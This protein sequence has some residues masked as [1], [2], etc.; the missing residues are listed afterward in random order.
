[1]VVNLNDHLGLT[2]TA[3]PA[4]IVF[5]DSVEWYER[6]SGAGPQADQIR[7]S[8]DGFTSVIWSGTNTSTN[9]VPRKVVSG[10]PNFT[11][12]L[13]I[14]FYGYFPTDQGGT[15][16]IDSLRIYAHTFSTLPVELLSFTGKA[17]NQGVELRW[18]TGS[19][20]DN[21]RFEILRSVDAETWREIGQVSGSGTTSVLS[22]Y[23]FVD[24]DPFFGT[25]YYRLRQVDTNGE[26]AYSPVVSVN[27]EEAEWFRL[28]EDRL[29]SE[30]PTMIFD[31]LG[32]LI[33]GP[34]REHRISQTGVLFLQQENRAKSARLFFS[35]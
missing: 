23:L 7:T 5:I 28:S 26:Y 29:I 20:Q 6:R 2:L 9:Y 13:D 1:M 15:L 4:S 16:R 3:L 35:P 19:E 8:A 17:T 24:N 30:E 18:A 10:F 21:D 33:S 34:S 12:T 25:N 22:E 31:G 32:R 14:R 11:T 27:I